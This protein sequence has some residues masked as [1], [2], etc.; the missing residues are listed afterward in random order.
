MNLCFRS[1]FGYV[2]LALTILFSAFLPSGL[3]EGPR[4]VHKKEI[5]KITFK[6]LSPPYKNY[7][8]FQ[9]YT[10]FPFAYASSSFSLVNAWWLAEISTLVYAEEAYVRRELNSVGFP[11]VTFSDKC[12]TQC[13]IAA[14]ARFAIVAFRGSEIWKR[15]KE[16]DVKRIFADLAADVDVRLSP[17]AAGGRVHHGFKQAMEEVWDEIYP[18]IK[19]LEARGCTI[20]MTGHSL[21]GALAMLAADRYQNVQGVYSFG[22]PRIG[23]LNFRRRFSV[24]AYRI[25]NGSDI[26]AQVP[27]RGVYRHVGDLKVIDAVGNLHLQPMDDDAREGDGP[28]SYQS[29]HLFSRNPKEKDRKVSRGVIP[30][31]IRDHVPVLYS[32][33]LWNNLL[34]QRF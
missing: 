11:D 1:T 15:D 16:I 19:S 4:A 22:A 2:G 18:V 30:A 23:D 5:P 17:W 27:A 9:N 12:S 13:F 6:N 21:G 7:K 33:F 8:Y 29:A 10:L 28:S 26:V 34:E 20:W 32:V 14:N 3:G 25:V 31:P 24:P